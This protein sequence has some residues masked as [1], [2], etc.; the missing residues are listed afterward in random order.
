MPS[1]YTTRNGV[2][3][4]N[5]GENTNSWAFVRGAQTLTAVIDDLVSHGLSG[6]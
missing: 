1:A 3:K 4:Q 5:P 6:A 2:E